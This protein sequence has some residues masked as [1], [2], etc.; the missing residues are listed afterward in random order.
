[1][2]EEEQ[3]RDFLGRA[4]EGAHTRPGI[5]VL[6]AL[7]CLLYF[8]HVLHYGYISDDTFITLRYARNLVQGH[9][10]VYNVGQKVEGFTSPLWTV[11]LAG[12]HALGLNLLLSARALGIAAGAVTLILCYNLVRVS[13]GFRIPRLLACA[14][15]LILAANNSF[16]CWAASGM[17]QT[18]YVCLIVGSLVAAFSGR[19]IWCVLLTAGVLLIRPEGMFLFLL[20]SLYFIVLRWTEKKR[21]LMLWFVSIG[22]TLAALY[23]ARWLY[24]GAWLPNTYYAKTGGGVRQLER[25]LTYLLDYAGDHEGLVILCLVVVCV[26]LF[27]KMKERF[28]ALGAAGFWG[29]TV[30]VGGDGLPMYRFALPAL[31]LLIVLEVILIGRAAALLRVGSTARRKSYAGIAVAVL[32]LVTVHAVRPMMGQHYNLYRYQKKVE[33]PR[34]AWVGK[35]LAEN[36]QDGETVACVPIG[37][38][39]YYSGLTVFDMMGLTDAHIAHRK[40]PVMGKGWPGHEKRDGPYILEQKPTYLLLGNI[41]VTAKPRDIRKQPFIPAHRTQAIWARERDIFE[42]DL[43]PVLYRPRS[44]EIAPGRFLNFYE[45]IDKDV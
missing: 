27:G 39:G 25:G 16:A 20:L 15:P 30:F 43:L 14:A 32:L 34:W 36:A 23:G 1:M 19:M 45:R 26:L 24:Y 17:E 8:I 18:A 11:I 42:T 21:G 41:D 5:Y 3:G 37:A 7:I 28:L 4:E 44:V 22:V 35:W 13:S 12:L 38:L 40:M 9:G 31:P 29:M 33:V 6:L 2:K 10:L